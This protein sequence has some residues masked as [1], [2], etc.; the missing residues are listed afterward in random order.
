MT[1]FL[2]NMRRYPLSVV[3]LFLVCY[4][5][6]YN[7]RDYSS[8]VLLGRFDKVLHFIMYASLCSLIWYEY[9]KCHTSFNVGR[10]L[11]YGVV[12][13]IFLGGFLELLQSLFTTWRSG[14]LLDFLFNSLGV[15]FAAF[16]SV[17]VTRPLLRSG[18]L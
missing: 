5:T 11:F 2:N 1:R 7:P 18:F 4:A 17:I 15:L 12:V 13:P 8:A 16:F 14:D 9:F 3:A 6:F 10:I